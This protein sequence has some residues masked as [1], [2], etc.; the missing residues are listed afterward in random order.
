MRAALSGQA[1]N[2]WMPRGM[3]GA[4]EKAG[5]PLLAYLEPTALAMAPLTSPRL[6]GGAAYNLGRASGKTGNALSR[7]LPASNASSQ[8]KQ[9]ALQQ[10]PL[11]INYLNNLTSP[12]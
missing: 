1:L 2:S 3:T 8:I 12:Q 4:V 6:M 10:L 7:L 11:T 9:K 5:L